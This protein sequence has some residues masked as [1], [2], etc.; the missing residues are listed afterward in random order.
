[1][2]FLKSYVF[3]CSMSDKLFAMDFALVVLS[4]VKG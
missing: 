4:H 1:M 2:L 3:R